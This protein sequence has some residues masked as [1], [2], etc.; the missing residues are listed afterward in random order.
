VTEAERRTWSAQK[1]CRRGRLCRGKIFE[2]E[3][4][5]TEPEAQP[6]HCQDSDIQG[7][8]CVSNESKSDVAQLRLE[9]DALRELSPRAKQFGS[10]SVGD[11]LFSSATPEMKRYEA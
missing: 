3:S 6:I 11:R 10:G 8:G 7:R 9:I 5:G 1:I 4:C 2:P